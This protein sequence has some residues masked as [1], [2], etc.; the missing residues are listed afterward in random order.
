M[1][2]HKRGISGLF[3]YF[4]GWH[5][6]IRLVVRFRLYPPWT[7]VISP[8]WR[9]MP[10]GRLA[11]G[12]LGKTRWWL[13]VLQT[14]PSL[15]SP[16]STIAEEQELYHRLHVVLPVLHLRLPRWRYPKQLG[17]AGWSLPGTHGR[18]IGRSIRGEPVAWHVLCFTMVMNTPVICWSM[19]KSTMR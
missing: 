9:D 12:M 10:V 18:R 3:H 5:P 4:H 8:K 11:P 19:S 6:P 15:G 17:T 2:E 16:P 1:E 7:M 14:C 13:F